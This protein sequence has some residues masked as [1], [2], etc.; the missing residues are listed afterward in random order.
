MHPAADMHHLLSDLLWTLKDKFLCRKNRNQELVVAGKRFS[1]QKQKSKPLILGFFEEK[2]ANLGQMTKVN[3][4]TSNYPCFCELRKR[5][6]YICCA[7]FQKS[8]ELSSNHWKKLKCHKKLNISAFFLLSLFPVYASHQQKRSLK[9]HEMCNFLLF[10]EALKSS[11]EAG[12]R[13]IMEDN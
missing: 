12:N 4:T 10:F 3:Q 11:A 6:S 1:R 7:Q 5:P 8:N 2:I 9:S 13:V